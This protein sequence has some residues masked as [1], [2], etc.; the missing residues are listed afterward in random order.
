MDVSAPP[1]A[2]ASVSAQFDSPCRI[3]ICGVSTNAI[4]TIR[5]FTGG[6]CPVTL[7]AMNGK[8]VTKRFP[9]D[10]PLFERIIVKL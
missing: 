6:A 7:F 4:L 2:G 1:P 5:K 8:L 3:Y 9:F 10:E